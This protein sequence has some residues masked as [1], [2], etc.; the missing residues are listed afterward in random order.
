MPSQPDY[1]AS[2]NRTRNGAYGGA[3]RGVVDQ[4]VNAK[5]EERDT[6]EPDM[7][8]QLGNLGADLIH[9]GELR[10][11]RYLRGGQIVQD[12]LVSAEEG[13]IHP[14]RDI[15]I[16]LDPV[17]LAKQSN[18]RKL[19]VGIDFLP[20]IDE[21]HADPLALGDLRVR[22]SGN[23]AVNLSLPERDHVGPAAGDGC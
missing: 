20:D 14:P 6:P 9:L 18:E 8:G 1:I 4:T 15:Y 2:A 23:E 11:Q 13:P 16:P 5:N 12:Q 7:T 10:P 21:R 22:R 3:H 17:S 19:L